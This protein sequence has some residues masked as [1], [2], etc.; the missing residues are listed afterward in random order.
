DL[1]VLLAVTGPGQGAQGIS[2]FLVDLK[3]P[4]VRIESDYSVMSGG[5]AHG[6]IVL[7]NVRVPAANLIGEEGQGFKLAMGRITLN[8]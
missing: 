8:R 6:D 2:A 1:A 3:A 7:D 5:G 4:G